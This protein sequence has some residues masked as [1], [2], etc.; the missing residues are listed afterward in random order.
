M[1]KMPLYTDSCYAD[2]G[3]NG[4][5][6]P[7]GFEYIRVAVQARALVGQCQAARSLCTSI[8]GTG[9]FLS[10]ARQSLGPAHWQ[11]SGRTS[12]AP[13]AIGPL[14]ANQPGPALREDAGV[15]SQGWEQFRTLILKGA[16]GGNPDMVS[17]LIKDSSR[18]T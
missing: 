4:D 11:G 12:L 1:D 5:G 6:A 7:D 15:S 14:W 10:Q 16:E 3:G 13:A 8:P 18:K 2:Y 9:I 17:F